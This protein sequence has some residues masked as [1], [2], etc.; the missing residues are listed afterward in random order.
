MKELKV[1]DW[2]VKKEGKMKKERTFFLLIS[3]VTACIQAGVDAK[4]AHLSN[5]WYPSDPIKLKKKLKELDDE[6]ESLY[7]AQVSGVRALIV[8]HAGLSYSGSLAAACFRLLDRKKVRRIVLLAPSHHMPFKG[9]ILPSYSSYRLHSGVIPVDAKVVRELASLGAPFSLIMESKKDPHY[10]EHALEV[11]LPLIQEYAPRAKI[12]PLIVG[13][14]D[15]SEV[16]KVSQALKKYLDK[17]TVVVVSS[18]FT[19]YGPRF[20][21]IPFKVDQA[22][23]FKIRSLDNGLLQ[24]IFNRSLSQFLTHIT[25]AESTVCGK[26]PLSVLLGLFEEGAFER[27]VPYLIGYDTSASKK[28]DHRNSVSYVGMAFG[29][30]HL[31]PVPMLT[32]YE[33]RSLVDLAY[34]VMENKITHVVEQEL[35]LP[36]V[37]PTLKRPSHL[38]FSLHKKSHPSFISQQKSKSSSLY[39]TVMV[40]AENSVQSLQNIQMTVLADLHDIEVQISVITSERSSGHKTRTTMIAQSKQYSGMAYC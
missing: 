39:R 15:P 14:L 33:R 10:K 4:K 5:E 13:S 31:G 7:N 20:D 8:P 24:P 36:I 17:E 37:T 25:E 35:L 3:L 30:P 16:K 27:E 21:N 19:H 12:I 28:K 1:Q 40:Q 11:E 2:V 38:F 6:A 9:V 32:E 29:K 22:T 26:N 34:A 18:D 23:P